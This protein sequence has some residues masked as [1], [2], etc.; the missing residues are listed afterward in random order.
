MAST[1][2]GIQARSHEQR[3][4]IVASFVEMVQAGTLDWNKTWDINLLRPYNPVSGTK[5]RGINR[6]WLS[7][8]SQIRG[9]EDCRW[10][11][12]KQ[13]IDNG[14]GIKKGS[15]CAYV[16]KWDCVRFA[17]DQEAE[18]EEGAQDKQSKP[19]LCLT[20]M[21]QVFNA[22]CVKGIPE[23][24][25]S[26]YPDETMNDLIEGF[27]ESSEAK[28]IESLQETAYYNITQDIIGLPA[29]TSFASPEDFL[30]TL[31]H[32]EAH[33]T[34]HVTRLNRDI[35]HPFGSP[36]YA[37][38][39]LRAELCAVF[40]EVETHLEKFGQLRENHAAYL[41][42][43]LEAITKDPAVLYSALNDAEKMLEYLYGSF[44]LNQTLAVA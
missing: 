12:F 34:A 29:R 36:E 35:R 1:K 14:W 25:G 37:L 41:G 21:F 44:R 23:P 17:P 18:T 6:L 2:H 42:H 19:R 24:E 43:W 15:K 7:E 3:K 8:L 5:Y 4:Q 38:E 39:E 28:I 20:A 31:F 11:T 13:A 16:E 26:L 32:E 9:Y 22:D 10:V 27:I 40:L 30:A 33:S